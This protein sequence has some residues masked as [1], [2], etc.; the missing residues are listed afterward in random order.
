MGAGKRKEG[1][2]AVDHL[3]LVASFNSFPASSRFFFI[4]SQLLLSEDRFSLLGISDLLS[5]QKQKVT[6]VSIFLLFKIPNQC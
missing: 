3:C 4:L 5:C 6:P 1:G 2:N